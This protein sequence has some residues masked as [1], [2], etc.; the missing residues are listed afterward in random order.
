MQIT[1]RDYKRVEKGMDASF[2]DV[3]E[4]KM[5]EMLKKFF[6]PKKNSKKGDE[7]AQYVKFFA[8]KAC[9]LRLFL[10]TSPEWL[11]DRKK[12]AK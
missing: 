3:K 6:L 2:S 7:L 9:N 11:Q 4:G 10:E 5:G 1:E 8:K 12:R